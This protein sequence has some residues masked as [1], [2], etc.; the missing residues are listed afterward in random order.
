MFHELQTA[1]EDVNRLQQI[2][3]DDRER[4]RSAREADEA[5]ADGRLEKVRDGFHAARKSS[6]NIHHDELGGVR[7]YASKTG[8]PTGEGSRDQAMTDK[9]QD[10]ERAR[11]DQGRSEEAHWQAAE[12]AAEK[13]EERLSEPPASPASSRRSG[14]T[15]A[16]RSVETRSRPAP[17]RAG[18]SV[19]GP[20]VRS[21]YGPGGPAG[22]CGPRL[23]RPALRT[24]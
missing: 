15:R 10:Q 9:K 12:A 1:I 8:A 4:S 13:E 6:I 17:P 16:G 20:R 19:R 22:P 18:A 23:P 11:R 7:D 14:K 3:R 21:P 2:A 5:V 24:T